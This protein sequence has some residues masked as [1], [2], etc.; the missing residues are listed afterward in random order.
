MTEKTVDSPTATSEPK[1]KTASGAR[2]IVVALMLTTVLLAALG[3]V[4]YLF[5]WPWLNDQW[6]RLAHIERQVADVSL[7]KQQ[8]AD[9]Q[10]QLLEMIEVDLQT[11]I[12][13]DRQEWERKLT[14][15]ETRQRRRASRVCRASARR[16]EWARLERPGRPFAGGRSASMAGSGG[17]FP[18]P[19]GSPTAAHCTGCGGGHQLTHAGRRLIA[20]DR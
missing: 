9:W 2:G 1:V 18:D 7:Q 8:A 14:S 15:S 11:A 12:A 17:D 4:I 5:G 19:L 13:V 16:S 10:G 3:A 6:Q 20:R